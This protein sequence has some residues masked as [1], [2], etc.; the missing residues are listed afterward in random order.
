MK[1]NFNV[2]LKITRVRKQMKS[3]LTRCPKRCMCWARNRKSEMT[4]S[5]VPIRY[6]RELAKAR[7]KWKSPPKRQHW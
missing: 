2:P 4:G 7:P 1:V 3:L 5:T 6:A